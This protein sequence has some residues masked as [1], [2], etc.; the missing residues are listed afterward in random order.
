[1]G[2][3]VRVLD[4]KNYAD[5]HWF[6]IGLILIVVCLSIAFMDIQ[7]SY[8]SQE[9]SLLDSDS[10]DIALIKNDLNDTTKDDLNLSNKFVFL[11]YITQNNAK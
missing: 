10:I 7:I 8:P 11:G 3:Y 6:L 5:K 1:M 9:P 2:E 4:V